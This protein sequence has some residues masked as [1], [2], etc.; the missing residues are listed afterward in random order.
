MHMRLHTQQQQQQQ[1]S[2]HVDGFWGQK[3]GK[4]FRESSPLALNLL[5]SLIAGVMMRHAKSQSYASTGAPL[6]PLPPRTIEWR[7]T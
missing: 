6:V 3:I 2:S 4:P 1:I 7:G 5:H